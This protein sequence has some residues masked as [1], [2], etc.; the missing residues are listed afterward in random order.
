MSN[1]IPNGMHLECKCK[2][3]VKGSGS[4]TLNLTSQKSLPPDPF[5]Q[6]VMELMKSKL[7][8]IILFLI[9]IREKTWG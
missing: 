9:L 8:F 6:V 7:K 2:A 4:I 1:K 3:G 5:L